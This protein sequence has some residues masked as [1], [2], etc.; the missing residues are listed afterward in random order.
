MGGEST[1]VERR[2]GRLARN[3][4]GVVTRERLLRAGLT[5]K[6]IDRRIEKDA[7]LLVHRGVYRVA[8]GAP[9]VEARYMAAVLACGEGALLAGHAAAYLLGIIRGEVPPPEV[10][11]RGKRV[12]PGVKTRRSTLKDRTTWKGIPVTSVAQT[13]VDLAGIL[14]EDDLART[15][16][17]AGVRHHTTPAQVKAALAR[18]PRVPGAAKLRRVISGEVRVSLSKLERG[19]LD[20][21][22]RHGLPLP[23]RRTAGSGSIE[24]IGAG[25]SSG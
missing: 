13:L 19:G 4:H 10:A 21:L 23:P 24:S 14:E 15:C 18:R 22:S 25:R 6:Q 3:A 8:H 9:S 11:T 20:L 1:T 12:V 7:L 2:I 16:H 17:E 5:V